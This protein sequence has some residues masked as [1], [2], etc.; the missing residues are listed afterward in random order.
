MNSVYLVD[1]EMGHLPFEAEV[2]GIVKFG[3]VNFI[4]IAV[5]NTLTPHTL[6]TGKI[7]Y[8]VNK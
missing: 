3:E 1:H 5:N 4:T 8:K 7:D 2:Q 6:P